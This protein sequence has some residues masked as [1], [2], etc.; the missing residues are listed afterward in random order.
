[1]ALLPDARVFD[2][3]AGSGRMHHQ[4]WNQASH[5]VGCDLKWYPD[6][7]IAYVADNRRVMRAID[8]NR[9]NLFD[10][11]AYG[12][13]WEQ[14]LI[15]AARRK[16]APGEKIGIV[17]T[18]GSALK[19]KLGSMPIALKKIAGLRDNV[20]GAARLQDSLIDR[21][22]VNLAKSLN[23]KILKRWQATGKTGAAVVYT[24]LVLQGL[25]S[26]QKC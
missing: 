20:A 11:D 19:M 3:F 25:S 14:C 18:D 12:N 16:V 23:C 21:A 7:R 17:L 5:Y 2:A 4:V 8:L 6:E 26:P 24:G 22:I 9:F 15:L 13:P 10:F 1:M